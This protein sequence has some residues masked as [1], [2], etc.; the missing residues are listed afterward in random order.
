MPSTSNCSSGNIRWK[1]LAAA[2]IFTGFSDATTIFF[3]RLFLRFVSD[4]LILQ[5]L[6]NIVHR[7]LKPDQHLTAIQ[8]VA[9]P[10][11]LHIL[12]RLVDINEFIVGI[13]NP[14]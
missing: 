11:R 4:C 2:W 14:D 1:P 10:E 13:Y 6:E 5:P 3:T 8:R 7:Q 12:S 9:C